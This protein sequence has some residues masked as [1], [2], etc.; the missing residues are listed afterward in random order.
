MQLYMPANGMFIGALFSGRCRWWNEQL[1]TDAVVTA[2][3]HIVKANVPAMHAILKQRAHAV[4]VQSESSEYFHADS[5]AAIKPA[6]AVSS[7]RR[8]RSDGC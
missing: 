5:P 8:A 6:E 3:K 1:T 7:K 2:L 4:F